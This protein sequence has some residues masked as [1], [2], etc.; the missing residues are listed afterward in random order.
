MSLARTPAAFG[1]AFLLAGALASCTFGPPHYEARLH[2]VAARSHSHQLALAVE[3]KEV[4][5][6]TGLNTFPNGG[7]SRVLSRRVKVYLVDLDRAS[8]TTVYEGKGYDDIPRPKSVWI[9]GWA[10]DELYFSFRGYGEGRRG[11]DNPADPRRTDMRVE[12]AGPAV[13]VEAPPAGLAVAANSGPPGAPPFV[14]YRRGHLQV[15][16]VVDGTLTDVAAKWLLTVHPETGEV[17]LTPPG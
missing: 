6:P 9:D 8:V 3:R 14:R 17:A 5:H 11:G 4:R 13:R 12:A 15:E 2:H 1:A 16:A 7:V 10:G